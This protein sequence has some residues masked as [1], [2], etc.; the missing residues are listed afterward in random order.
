MALVV[1]GFA[2]PMGVALAIEGPAG[3]TADPGCELGK[4][5]VE[6]ATAVE[7]NEY[8]EP[9]ILAAIDAGPEL[10]W[11]LPVRI[12]SDPYHRNVE[13]IMDTRAIFRSSDVAQA[14]GLLEKHQVSLILLCQFDPLGDVY[15][16]ESFHDRLLSHSLPIESG[17]TRL[18]AASPFVLYAYEWS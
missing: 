14:Q 7:T 2:V 18:P 11:R 1:V 6:L 9:V 10:L 15:G 16:P 12:V 8:D 13:G 3:S 5:M 17:F 4:T